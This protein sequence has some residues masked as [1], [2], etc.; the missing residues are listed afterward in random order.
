MKTNLRWWGWGTV[1]K[2]FPADMAGRL[3][4][5]LRDERA[6]P[7]VESIPEAF[8]GIE[9]PDPNIG[10]TA[11]EALLA[12]AE[13]HA[14]PFARLTH[15]YG[16]GYLDLLRLRRGDVFH[17]PDAVVWPSSPD[18]IADVLKVCETYDIGV[19]PY[20]G[21]TS[22]VGEVEPVAHHGGAISLDMRGMNRMISIDPQAGL[23][24][25]QAGIL[26]PDL[27]AML[28]S[29]GFTLGH[30]PES[31]EY[32]TLGGWVA[33]NSVG[34]NAIRVGPV[35]NLIYGMQVVLPDGRRVHT[36]MASGGMRQFWVGSRGALGVISEVSVRISQQPAYR[37]YRTAR[38]AD[39]ESAVT[40]LRLLVQMEVQP[41]VV[42]LA[43]MEAT[44]ID[45]HLYGPDVADFHRTRQRI[46][47]WK[48]ESR[49]MDPAAFCRMVMLFEGDLDDVGWRSSMAERLVRQCG[50]VTAGRE[51]AQGWQK[52]RFARP[53]LRDDL[54]DQSVGIDTVQSRVSWTNLNAVYEQ[55]A[56]ALRETLGSP[57]VVSARIGYAWREGALLTIQWMAPQV[58]NEVDR[59]ITLR[60]VAA[61]A[62]VAAGGTL[63]H[64]YAVEVPPEAAAPGGTEVLHDIL[65]SAKRSF[66]AK[67]I[68]NPGKLPLEWFDIARLNRQ[69]SHAGR[70]HPQG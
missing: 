52:L 30:F 46:R 58:E 59:F 5:Y 70:F 13:L 63:D 38:F 50:G 56:M 44:L 24:T 33:T 55:V 12:A 3:L 7:M 1:D 68:M 42:E 17:P 39:W 2:V 22:P 25:F 64:H 66:D 47:S 21:G 43:D 20:G 6:F 61:R 14:T 28:N 11:R 4:T 18:E 26:G 57:A 37:I 60:Q 40:C 23:A 48:M 45:T 49:A 51:E 15:A 36:D 16:K 65:R 67:T 69:P 27:E 62:A 34:Q 35:E 31:F 9:M 54:L 41:A 32:S 10:G 8:N 19:V 53:Y 29:Y